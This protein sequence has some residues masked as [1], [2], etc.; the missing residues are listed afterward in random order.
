MQEVAYGIAAE[1]HVIGG[2]YSIDYWS[3]PLNLKKT[4]TLHWVF[5]KTL[6]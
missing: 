2:T 1:K 5:F 3:T 6:L 4:S